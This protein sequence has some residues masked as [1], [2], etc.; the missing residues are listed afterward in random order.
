MLETT[1]LLLIRKRISSKNIAIT[2]H[3]G[4]N[5]LCF[6]FEKLESGGI[7]MDHPLIGK[8]VEITNRKHPWFEERGTVESFENTNL[9]SMGFRVELD[10]RTSCFVWNETDMRKLSK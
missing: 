5:A 3:R 6:S 2:I 4:L 9:G 7:N 10:N 8:R 1:V